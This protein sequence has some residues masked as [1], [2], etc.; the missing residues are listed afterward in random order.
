MIVITGLQNFLGG[1]KLKSD[2]SLIKEPEAAKAKN[3]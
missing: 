1:E 3:I 2:G